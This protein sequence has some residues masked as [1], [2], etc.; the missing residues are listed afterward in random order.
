MKTE[1][2]TPIVTVIPPAPAATTAIVGATSAP[3][4]PTI[5]QKKVYLGKTVMAESLIGSG[6][7]PIE[8]LN[9]IVP[10]HGDRFNR[11]VTS[12]IPKFFV[13]SA[14][15]RIGP[16]INLTYLHFAKSTTSNK[17]GFKISST[18]VPPTF[19]LK[20][21]TGTMGRSMTDKFLA[22][23]IK[24]LA[25]QLGHNMTIGSDPE[26]FIEDNRNGVVIPAFTFLNSKEEAERTPN[27][28]GYSGNQ[29]YYWDGFQ[30]EFETAGTNTCLAWQVDSVQLGL[31]AVLAAAKRHNQF[32]KLSTKTVMD[33]PAEELQN[34]SDEHIAVGCLPSFNAYG[35]K[36]AE[37]AQR[38][39]P[40]RCAGGHIHFGIGATQKDKATEIVKTLDAILAVACVS[41]FET[42]DNPIRREFYGL[43]GEFRLPAHGIEYRVLSNAWLCHPLAQN[44]VFDFARK[45]VVFGQK[46]FRRMWETTEQ[47]TIDC[48]R[49]CDV[50]RAREI[51][52]RNEEIFKGILSAACNG[53]KVD[54][55]HKVWMTGIEEAIAHPTDIARNWVLE[56]NWVNHSDGPGKNWGKACADIAAGRKV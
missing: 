18:Y 55:L 8:A 26:I 48:V 34:A 37:V 22:H 9:V 16:S 31:K 3:G 47:E 11:R 1:I 27:Q 5:P 14:A 50:Q 29:R 39:M 49:M 41:L 38:E 25:T 23:Q 30:A 4:A 24:N 12:K 52:A 45:V 56:G 53:N 33:I 15:T 19:E 42:F 51:L 17:G 43:P 28:H 46:G 10:D 6:A 54:T 7:V 21:L 35:L 40:V 36:G 20:R 13:V 32:A 44:I 2:A